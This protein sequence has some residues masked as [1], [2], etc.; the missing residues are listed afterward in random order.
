M[1]RE[2]F[3]PFVDHDGVITPEFLRETGLLWKINH[4]ILHPIGL[5]IGLGV[6]LD[7]DGEVRHINNVV[8]S[9]H[10]SDDG[11]WEFPPEANAEKSATWQG[12]VDAIKAAGS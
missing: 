9:L 2:I 1:R 7:D 3:V 4:D 8:L 12:F 11:V 6:N 10:I 5:A